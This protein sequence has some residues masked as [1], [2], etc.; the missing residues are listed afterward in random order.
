MI[1]C[2]RIIGNKRLHL[3]MIETF[4]ITPSSPI[5]IIVGRNGSGKSTIQRECTPLP[6]HHKHYTKEGSKYIRLTCPLGESYEL[7][8]TFKRG[9]GEHSFLRVSDGE[10]LNKGK[11]RAVQLE[12]VEDIFGVNKERMEILLGQVKFS[13]MGPMKRQEWLKKLSPVCMDYVFSQFNTVKGLKR[14]QDGVVKYQQQR[15]ARESKEVPSESEQMALREELKYHLR[16]TEELLEMKYSLKEAGQATA[17]YE[18]QLT[19]QFKGTIDIA[20]RIVKRHVALPPGITIRSQEDHERQLNDARESLTQVDAII[21]HMTDEYLR[22]QQQQPKKDMLLDERVIKQTREEIATLDQ[23]ITALTRPIQQ[24]N[25]T[26]PLLDVSGFSHAESMIHQ[27]GQSWLHLMEIFPDNSK[28]YYSRKRREAVGEELK[29]A[30]GL[31]IEHE[32]KRDSILNRLQQIKTCQSITCPSCEHSFLPGVRPDE[33]D[34]LQAR[35]TRHG[36]EID[37]LG[38]IIDKAKAYCEQFEEYSGY[39]R[40]FKQ[41]TVESDQVF[42][43][44]WSYCIEHRVMTVNPRQWKQD[45]LLWV[46]VMEY[47]AKLQQVEQRRDV[48]INKLRYVDEIDKHA[49]DRVNDNLKR[50]ETENETN[51][52]QRRLLVLEIEALEEYARKIGSYQHQMTKTIDGIKGLLEQLHTWHQQGLLKATMKES[53]AHQLALARIKQEIHQFEIRCGVLDDINEQLTLNQQRQDDLK[54]I[55]RSLG[56]HEGLIGRYL[57]GFLKNVT[58]FMNAVINRVWTYPM[59]ILPSKINKDELDYRFPL[60]VNENEE[61][62]DDVSEGSGSQVDIIDFAFRLLVMHFMNLNHLPLYFDEFGTSFDDEHRHTL[63]EMI[64]SMVENGQVP[65]VLFISHY[66]ETH[67]G[68]A[69]ADVCV[70]DPNNITLPSVYNQHVAIS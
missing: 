47:K 33:V 22:I 58:L 17:V 59:E 21:K 31:R 30:R 27:V 6:G 63:I 24:Y 13:T 55:Q 14:D 62:C 10:E 36:E 25:G 18:Q 34:Q 48:L 4:E 49:I 19:Q 20:K 40:Q 57:M 39:V 67:G 16:R 26:F 8:S 65:Q 7:T 43:T 15:L 68:F 12:L 50:I 5:Q 2:L 23:E 66:V 38:K 35:L 60:I 41:L 56:P 44:L 53:E 64:S 46:D 1:E 32:G 69:N 42:S 28:G 51:A 29:Q 54:L 61:P 37:R 52:R 3:S 70:V 45:A 9:T 11:T